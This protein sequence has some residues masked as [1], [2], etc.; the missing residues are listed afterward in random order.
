M[1]RGAS[2][3]EVLFAI[4]VVSVGLLGVV[5]IFPVAASQQRKARIADMTAISGR[6]AVGVFKA[7]GM[8]APSNWIGWNS[9]LAT[10]QFTSIPQWSNGIPA[11]PWL[12]FCIDPRFVAYHSSAAEANQAK[13]FPCYTPSGSEPRMYRITLGNGM[14][15]PMTQLQAD[16]I[17]QLVDDLLYNRKPSTDN[18]GAIPYDR[19]A[20]DRPA[21]Q[22]FYRLDDDGVPSS[23]SIPLKRNSGGELSWM[24]TLCPKH[25]L[26]LDPTVT[27][28]SDYVLSIVILHQRPADFP[29]DANGERVLGV[30]FTEIGGVGYAGG[31]ALLTWSVP[32]TAANDELAKSTILKVRS[33]QWLMLSG[34]ATH[35]SGVVLPTFRWYRVTDA[36]TEPEYHTAESHYALAVSLSGQDW[37]TTLLN[38]EATI[39]SGVVGV[40]EKTISLER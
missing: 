29:M 19:S 33:Q 23:P 21:A 1:R 28:P 26:Y 3:L 12:S 30:D 39:V 2:I 18:T 40:Y 32:Q 14:G 31:E 25:E 27:P 11:Q 15:S 8:S 20:N 35:R 22:A 38:Q 24:A 10:P 6:S 36:E 34:N 13:Y 5:S 17:F 9:A 37:D 16:S 4:L 7:R